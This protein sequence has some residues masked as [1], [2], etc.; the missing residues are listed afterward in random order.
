MKFKHFS[1]LMIC[2]LLLLNACKITDILR[3]TSDDITTDIDEIQA[4]IFPLDSAAKKI[5]V[6]ILEGAATEHSKDNIDTLAKRITYGITHF[7]NER[8]KELDTES[9]GENL[10]TGLTK[11][12]KSEG[13]RDTIQLLVNH[14]FQ[15]LRS[16][17]TLTLDSLVITLTSDENKARVESMVA[18]LF[19]E[20]NAR[21]ANEFINTSLEGISFTSI[22]DS[23]RAN[24]LNEE[25]QEALNNIIPTKIDSILDKADGILNKIG[26]DGES[27]IERN[28]WTI[29]LGV[30]SL[31]LL[32]TL[33]FFWRKKRQE[34]KMNDVIMATINDLKKD[35]VFDGLTDKIQQN[36]INRGIES[37]L[38]KR[39]IELGLIENTR[40]K[41]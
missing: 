41:K 23:L 12:I 28:I 2:S 25:T 11:E 30:A 18:S 40:F 31:M 19:A 38:N 22:A 24:L 35:D 21:K 33:L 3:K 36:A 15:D 5:V 4:E 10:M 17:L 16:E 7:L 26:E 29:V 13:F 32:G 1:I 14:V 39:L 27:F 37:T 34:S 8:L 9:V 20:A 6:G